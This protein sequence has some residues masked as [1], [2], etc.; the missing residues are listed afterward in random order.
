MYN[1]KGY[2]EIKDNFKY[3]FLFKVVCFI[4]MRVERK[5]EIYVI[6]VYFSGFKCVNIVYLSEELFIENFFW[7]R[8]I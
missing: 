4:G 6:F 5:E 7:V 1:C 2:I 8:S 3:V